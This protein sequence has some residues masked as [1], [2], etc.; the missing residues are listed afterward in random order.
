M[1]VKHMLQEGATATIT[2]SLKTTSEDNKYIL[3]SRFGKV[4]IDMDNAI[5]FP[6]GL[7][8]MPDKLH[9]CL[10]DFPKTAVSEFKILQSLNDIELSF[11]VLPIALGNAFIERQ[12]IEEI[13]KILAV[14]IDDIGLVLIASTHVTP[15][16]K[17][18]SVNVR[19]PIIINTKEKAA[20]QYVFPQTKYAIRH[21]LTKAQH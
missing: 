18:I 20:A 16:G 19:A 21:M 5:Y 15:Q 13:A 8:G 6:S 7:L 3:E 4:T 10:T 2:Q 12:D 14:N 17:Q 11:V 1:Q 9:F